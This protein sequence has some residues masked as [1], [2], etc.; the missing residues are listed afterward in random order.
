M[1][2]QETLGGNITIVNGGDCFD[3]KGSGTITEGRLVEVDTAN[4]VFTV[5]AATANS[6]A[7]IG[8]VDAT[9]ESNDRV[10]VHTGG[11]AR[12]YNNSGATISANILVAAN[13][14][15]TIKEYINSASGTVVGHTL[16]SITDASFGRVYVNP[17]YNPVP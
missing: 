3:F 17:T 4:S 10:L 1:A 15:G 2:L 7:V 11:I 6:K 5:K 8:Y 9:Y 14:A 12:L 13:T 16:E